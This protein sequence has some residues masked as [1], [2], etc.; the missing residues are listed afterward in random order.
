MV[1][2]LR[3][4]FESENKLVLEATRGGV[5]R[6]VDGT[7]QA[8]L[9]WGAAVRL[10]YLSEV[11]EG[12][13]V[14]GRDRLRNH[15]VG[16][17]ARRRVWVQSCLLLALARP[18]LRLHSVCGPVF[19]CY[20]C[21]L[22]LFACPIGMSGQFQC[23]APVP[24]PGHRD[25]ASSSARCSAR[26]SAAGPARSGLFRTCSA[27][28]R[29]P[30]SNCR[31]GP[32]YPRYA[33]LISLVI[34]VPY[35]YGDRASAVLLPRLPGRGPRRGR[36]QRRP[37][38]LGDRRARAAQP[39]EDG[40]S[41]RG[42]D[43]HA[44]YPPA[45]VQHLLPAGG[46]LQPVQQGL[47]PEAAFSSRHCKQCGACDKMCR[48]DVLPAVDANNTECIRCLECTRCQAITISTVF[49]KPGDTRSP[50]DPA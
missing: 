50:D 17:L 32:G 27:A 20:S 15:K 14:H 34:I 8:N 6:M 21:P 42:A 19:H 16:W 1:K 38:G 12:H 30:S 11:T 23:A 13:G 25:A 48:Y 2:V 45:V 28:C 49:N 36:A 9:Q 22:S 29:P 7:T 5:E 43:R 40:H 44:V 10:P 3:T 18:G 46:D 39:S 24:L 35:L 4:I 37:G 33:V 47:T 26:P 41:R 31:P